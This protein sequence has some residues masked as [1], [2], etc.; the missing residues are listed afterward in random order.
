VSRLRVGLLGGGWIARVH[1][2]A[3]ADAGAHLVS[4]CDIDRARA[5]AVAAEAGAAAYT[6]WEPMLAGERLDALWICTPPMHHRAPAEAAFAEGIPVYLEKPIARTVADGE[7]IVSAAAAAEVVCAV[8]YQWHASDLV[9]RARQLLAGEPPVLLLG[10][11][12]GPVAGR[13]WFM[14]PGQGGGQILE[15]GSHHIDLQRTLAGEVAA[16]RVWPMGLPLGGASGSEIDDALVMELRFASGAA[17]TAHIAWTRDGHPGIYTTD[18]LAP[19]VTLTLELGRTP[20]L[21]G[22]SG[23]R[24]VDES[25]DDP[26]RLSIR[27]FFDAVSAH[28]RDGVA[29]APDDALRTLRVAAAC[30]RSLVEGVEVRI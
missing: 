25:G 8:G 6:D 2:A 12:F 27:R 26:V 7:A 21:R 3:I 19:D 5:E 29:C 9:D 13:S 28:D 15:R 24:L 14:D 18:V 23:E 1:V 16:V 22:A 10:R 30:E 17:G 4:V 11:N 20:R